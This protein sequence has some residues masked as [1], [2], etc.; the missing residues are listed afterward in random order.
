MRKTQT[1]N[2]IHLII[3]G[4]VDIIALFVENMQCLESPE[5]F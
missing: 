5:M 2:D 3:N 4:D 1:F